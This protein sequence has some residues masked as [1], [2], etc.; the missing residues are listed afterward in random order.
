[1]SE[2]DLVHILSIL[3]SANLSFDFQESGL[4]ICVDLSIGYS[5]SY[6]IA[7]LK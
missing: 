7:T 6:E 5:I 1:M 4:S 3:N 2:T